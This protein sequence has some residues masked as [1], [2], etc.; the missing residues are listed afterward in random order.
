[1]LNLVINL[2]ISATRCV[3]GK[4]SYYQRRAEIFEFYKNQSTQKTRGLDN[5]LNSGSIRIPQPE[6]YY[7]F[8][9][10]KIKNAL[11][12]AKP[13]RDSKILEI[14]CNLGQMTFVLAGMGY[15]I[16]GFD[17]SANAIEKAQMRAEHF[18][19]KNISF[20]VQDA[21]CYNDHNEEKYDVIFSFSAFR[22]FPDPLKALKESFRVLKKGGVA[23]IDFPN[24]FCP[25]FSIIKPMALIKKHI[26]D[27]LFTVSK[28]RNMMEQ[29]GF[30]DIEFRKFLFSNKMLPGFLLPLMKTADFILERTPLINSMSAIIMVKGRK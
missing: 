13:K 5:W 14:G 17:L 1:M 19:L 30:Q 2:T 21:E 6:S 3:F 12:M 9:D 8:E 27:H 24:L 16:A 22:Y 15:T 26:H 18:K 4:C 20:E 23:V 11:E 7:Y 25:W 29:A 10:R 28:I